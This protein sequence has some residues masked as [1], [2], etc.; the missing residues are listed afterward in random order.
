MSAIYIYR[1]RERDVRTQ[2]SYKSLSHASTENFSKEWF[3]TAKDARHADVS[4]SSSSCS[5]ILLMVAEIPNNQPPFGMVPKPV[6]NN[7]RNSTELNW[8]ASFFWTIH[9][10]R[11][12]KSE[13]V[14]KTSS[15]VGGWTNP[16][17]E[18]AR[19]NVGSS[20]PIF[21]VKTKDSWNHYPVIQH[22]PY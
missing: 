18:Y 11:Q 4:G 8:L 19:Q 1:E 12:H 5:S 21:G 22:L 13:N 16:F 20:C 9:Q 6:V 17:E 14:S 2:G 7:G 15:I 10:K 3:P